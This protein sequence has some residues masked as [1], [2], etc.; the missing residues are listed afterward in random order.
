M[1][2][3]KG[4]ELALHYNEGCELE[5][6]EYVSYLDVQKSSKQLEKEIE[7]YCTKAWEEWKICKEHAETS[8]HAHYLQLHAGLLSFK[9][10]LT[11]FLSGSLKKPHG[12]LEFVFNN[13]LEHVRGGLFSAETN[14]FDQTHGRAMNS[15][16]KFDNVADVCVRA[17][18][19]SDP[20]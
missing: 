14:G 3:A 12:K 11:M 17:Y 15:L 4:L 6:G 5:G 18:E 2:K 20:R 9:E 7:L 10:G 8:G 1:D 16:E 19:S 13:A